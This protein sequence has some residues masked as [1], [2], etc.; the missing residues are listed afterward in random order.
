MPVVVGVLV[1]PLPTLE[2]PVHLSAKVIPP[3][4]LA[5][6]TS[7]KVRWFVEMAV[8]VHLFDVEAELFGGLVALVLARDKAQ[9]RV[10][11]RV[12]G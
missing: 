4:R 11:A 9:L 2:A 3:G 7:T 6:G 10:L 5:A 8:E 12:R 1:D